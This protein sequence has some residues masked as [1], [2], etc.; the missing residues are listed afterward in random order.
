MTSRAT[1][2]PL[3]RLWSASRLL[4]GMLLLSLCGEPTFVRAA[5][6]ETRVYGIAQFGR[7]GQ[8]GTP[9]MTHS[10]HTDTAAAFA[11]E[12]TR[13]VGPGLWSDVQSV[14]NSDARAQYFTDSD[15]Q[16]WGEDLA[17]YSGTDDGDVLFVH[18]HGAHR[19]DASYLVMG[20]TENSCLVNTID[21]MRFGDTFGDL[22]IAV[23]KA[24]QSGDYDVW[25]NNKY[26]DLVTDNSEFSTWNAFHGDSS[27]GSH[28]T[29]YV[30]NYS[31]RSF[32]DGV[33]ENWLDLAYNTF[34]SGDDCPV[35]IV[36][37]ETQAK[38]DSMYEHGGFSDR[39][40][41]GAKTDSSIY[42]VSKCTPTSGSA[43]P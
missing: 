23:V 42:F 8:C 11:R 39:Q 24:C 19:T 10:V 15:R 32:D 16:S 33:G 5:Y 4:S 41:T 37:G 28:V 2:K 38:R 43:L 3:I 9:D 34:S 31:Q 20:S 22:E 27:C 12:F 14:N 30:G 13:R 40:D 1:R 29:S 18:T 36:F 25:K 7:R 26:L 6:D 35:S 17:A 21:N